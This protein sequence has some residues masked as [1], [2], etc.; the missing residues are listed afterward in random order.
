M[1]I[2]VIGS[3]IAGLGAAWALSP[4]HDVTLIEA[5]SRAGG[6]SRTLDVDIDGSAVSVDTG[7]IV[8]NERNYPNLM[9]LLSTLA[10]PTV[11]SD[12]SFAVSLEEGSF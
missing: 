7:F 12:M 8:Y 3:G 6:H 10:V 1:R 11:E 2:A 9:N 4:T 5:E